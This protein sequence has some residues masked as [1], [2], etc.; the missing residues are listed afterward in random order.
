M[1]LTAVYAKT[2]ISGVS[3]WVPHLA[4]KQVFNHRLMTI[5]TNRELFASEMVQN[6]FKPDS[7]GPLTECDAIQMSCARYAGSQF[8][9]IDDSDSCQP[10]T[11]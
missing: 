11:T 1:R 3:D 10:G 4:R 7:Y 5:H 9:P 8:N 6:G 2:E